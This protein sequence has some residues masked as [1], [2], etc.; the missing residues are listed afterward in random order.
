VPE[1]EAGACPDDDGDGYAACGCPLAGTPCDCDDRD[2]GVYPGAPEACSAGRDLD[3]DGVVREACPAGRGCFES[4][5]V[6][7]CV[8]L[9]DFGCAPG[10]TFGRGEGGACLCAPEDCTI[11]G[12]PPGTVCD[13]AKACVPLCHPGVVCPVG[14][15]CEGTAGCVDPC[16]KVVCPSGAAC[17]D[18]A[19]VAPCDCA[20]SSCGA[21][22][23]CDT[24]A[25]PARCAE[26]ACIGIACPAEQ[27]CRAGR[28]VDDCEGVVCPTEQLCRKIAVDGGPARGACVDLCTPDPC[29]PGF[30]CDW[31]TA[32]CVPRATA[33]GGLVG[34]S[35]P[36]VE[37]LVVT[38][39]GFTCTAVALGGASIAGGVLALT[40]AAVLASL[41]RRRSRA[42][43]RR[44]RGD[45][46]HP[47][48]SPRNT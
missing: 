43:R 19:C 42:A 27:H 26:T 13:D 22:E 25:S 35:E 38:G 44:R 1:C 10:S 17:R 47:P 9:S 23:T 29:A 48:S 14:L 40:S 37:A 33:E 6:P 3:C 39:G 36:S 5:C 11:F 24:T 2:P 31:R 34:T 16:A 45:D 28:C 8:P 46:R 7:E 15:R 20:G 30:V 21:G 41:A 18:G 12:C 32:A 4:V